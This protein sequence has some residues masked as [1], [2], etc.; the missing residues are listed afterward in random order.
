MTTQ[1]NV[2]ERQS[3]WQVKRMVLM[4]LFMALSVIG[5]MIKIP[6]PTGTVALDSAPGFLGAALLGWRE[7]AIIAALGHLISSYSAGMPLTI[8]V[9]LLIALE[10]AI[11]AALYDVLNRKTNLF[12]A[13]LIVTLVNGVGMPLT[14]APFFGMAFFYSMVLPLCV[15]SFINALVAAICYKILKDRSLGQ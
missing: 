1:A 9:H 15:A 7:G 10:M 6:S 13:V 14:M 5:A 2:Q 8:P 3:F 4:A 12:L 11:A